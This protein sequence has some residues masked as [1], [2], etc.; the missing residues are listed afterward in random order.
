[1]AFFQEEMGGGGAIQLVSR[2]ISLVVEV[3]SAATSELSEFTEGGKGI[4]EQ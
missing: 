1:M 3:G 4:Q 2:P